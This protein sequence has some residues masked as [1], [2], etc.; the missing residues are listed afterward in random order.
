MNPGPF[1]LAATLTCGQCFR[2]EEGED[3]SFSGVAGGR[4][5]TLS[6]LAP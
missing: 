5:L 2:W 4:E 3:G 6:P 1:D